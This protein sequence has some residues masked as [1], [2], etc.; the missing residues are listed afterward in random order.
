[1]SVKTKGFERAMRAALDGPDIKDVEWSRHGHDFNVKRVVVRN[2]ARGIEIDGSDGHHI[3]HRLAF[4]PDD[5]VY[6]K[7]TVTRDG[8]VENLEINVKTSWDT[9]KEWFAD[10]LKILGAA[11]AIAAKA[12]GPAAFE[13]VPASTALLDGSWKGDAAFLIANVISA[14][15]LRAM[16]ELGKATLPDISLRTATMPGIAMH[17][18]DARTGPPRQ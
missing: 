4:R 18:P 12:D 10:G 15:T 5:Q 7:C 17:H 14:A 1:M 16:P 8:K 13:P 11:A 6:Y 3:S 2:V 9:L